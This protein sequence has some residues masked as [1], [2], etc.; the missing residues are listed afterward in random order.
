[1]FYSCICTLCSDQIPYRL[2]QDNKCVLTFFSKFSKTFLKHITL[3][4]LDSGL[5][6]E[7]NQDLVKLPRLVSRSYRSNRKTNAVMMRSNNRKQI[8]VIML[9]Y[10]C[11]ERLGKLQMSL[12]RLKSVKRNDQS[13]VISDE[14]SATGTT[15]RVEPIQICI[16]FHPTDQTEGLGH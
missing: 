9:R 8:N 6:V 10:N 2:I 13:T 5:A 7:M 14:L 12:F 11:E 1:M 16:H 15:D 4:K 3:Y